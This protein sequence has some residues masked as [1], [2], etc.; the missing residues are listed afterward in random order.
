[1]TQKI[2]VV[3]DEEDLLELVK[4]NLLKEGYE[5]E[6]V[7]SGE[8][9]IRAARNIFPDLILLDLMLIGTDG[10]TVTRILKGDSK[11][12]QIPIA[13]LSARGEE[14]DIVTGLELGAEDYIT[15]PFSPKIL[16]AR[17]KTILRRNEEKQ[18]NP[19]D[20]I[21][22]HEISID[23]NRFEVQVNKTPLELSN[24]EFKLLSFLARRPGWVFTRNQI[25]SAVRGEDCAVTDRSVDVHIVS[26]RKKMGPAG[27]YIESIRGVGYRFKES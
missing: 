21:E 6:C 1:M 12:A 3:D 16:L 10:F 18:K 9:A 14:A 23:S 13:I 27:K 25:I 7:T 20:Q 24:T 19:N 5:V 11:T 22:V 15:K 4:Y 26:L 8:D 2:L 17:V